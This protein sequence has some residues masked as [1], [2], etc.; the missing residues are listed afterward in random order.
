MTVASTMVRNR[1]KE[2]AQTSMF[3]GSKDLLLLILRSVMLTNYAFGSSKA[4][5]EQWFLH[6]MAIAQNESHLN[7]DAY[8]QSKVFY[9]GK[10]V[11]SRTYGLL[12]QTLSNWNRSID[13]VKKVLPAL[14]ASPYVK[15]LSQ[16]LGQSPSHFLYPYNEFGAGMPSAYQLSPI[17][18]EMLFLK[19][20]I[21]EDYVFSS[22]GWVPLKPAII[23]S[24]NWRSIK[25]DPQLKHV[26]E[27]RESGEQLLATLIHVNGRHYY[28]K[29]KM[30]HKAR[31]L[32]DVLLFNQYLSE[33][34]KWDFKPFGDIKDPKVSSGFLP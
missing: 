5:R 20:S 16:K 29:T 19:S 22:H 30:Y 6:M 26:L 7:H 23:N 17:L 4:S 11:V 24:S 18:G 31:L 32:Q 33:D 1:Y 27:D 8:N 3:T 13:R 34:T 25:Q 12:Q 14:I 15:W 2:L 21:D 9:E 10:T 28:Q